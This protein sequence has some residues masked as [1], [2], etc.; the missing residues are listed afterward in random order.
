MT[1][2]LMIRNTFIIIS[3][4]ILF[5]SLLYS[6]AMDTSGKFT[7]VTYITKGDLNKDKIADSVIVLQ[8]TVN[9]ISPYRLKIFLSKPNRQYFLSVESDSAIEPQFPDGKDSYNNPASFSD[10]TIASGILSI[11]SQL[12]RGHYEHKFRYLNGNFELIGFTEVGS[13]GRGIMYTTDFNLST[14]ILI[15]KSERYDTD[16]LLS[17]KKKIVKI[18]PLPKLQNFKPFLSDIY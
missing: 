17:K 2:T 7:N 13:D 16:R 12:T 9:D 11:T 3:V 14:G 8:D 15:E 5:P 4:I 18:R 10:I 6:Q 1:N